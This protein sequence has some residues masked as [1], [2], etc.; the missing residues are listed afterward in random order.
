MDDQLGTPRDR[1]VE[2]AVDLPAPDAVL[3]R[4]HHVSSADIEVEDV[5]D[6]SDALEVLLQEAKGPGVPRHR[7]SETVRPHQVHPP[8]TR[9][10]GEDL[11]VPANLRARLRGE[12]HL[13]PEVLVLTASRPD[14]P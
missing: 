9:P 5:G 14:I 3:H 11:V 12:A 13:Q 7:T 4:R 1:G 2:V 10:A 8:N 6:C